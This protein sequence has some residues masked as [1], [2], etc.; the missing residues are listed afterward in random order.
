MHRSEKKILFSAI[1]RRIIFRKGDR[2]TNQINNTQMEAESL[3]T[4]RSPIQAIKT[5]GKKFNMDPQNPALKNSA[6]YI[7]TCQSMTRIL[8]RLNEKRIHKGQ[9]YSGRTR[10]RIHGGHREK[11]RDSYTPASRSIS[12]ALPWKGSKER[13]LS[14]N[15]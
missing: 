7:S 5:L 15:K 14:G 4:T 11:T 10:R 6:L 9:R 13:R 1:H 3:D 2:Q 12:S 8:E